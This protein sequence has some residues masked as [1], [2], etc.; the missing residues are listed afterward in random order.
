[1]TSGKTRA[2]LMGGIRIHL[3]AL[4]KALSARGVH[5][6]GMNVPAR[7]EPSAIADLRPDIV[8]VDVA[9]QSV[10]ET[11]SAVA[12]LASRAPTI[13]LGIPESDDDFISWLEM[14]V[15]GFVT[16]DQGIDDLVRGMK[17]TTR[18]EGILPEAAAA[19]LFR[20]ITRLART[21]AWTAQRRALTERELE[22]ASLITMGLSNKQIATRLFVELS[23]VKNHI[24][25]VF[26]KL[27]VH[28]R[29]QCVAQLLRGSP[30]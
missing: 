7:V 17:R 14:G 2:V 15:A 29:A 25:R 24:H 13:V 6:V 8:V 5:V 10:N 9:G 20:Q 19:S 30:S 16:N 21:G 23:T 22:V 1:M 27:N 3:E 26:E 4:A 28:S 11:L 18:G 12:W